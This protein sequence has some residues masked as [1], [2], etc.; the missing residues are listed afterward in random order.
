MALI[1]ACGEEPGRDFREIL[2]EVRVC[3]S[4]PTVNGIDVSYYQGTINWDRVAAAGVR[5]A[6]IRTGDGYFEDPQFERN[7]SEARR[8][9]IYRGAYHYFRPDKSPEDQADIVVSK[10]G[11]LGAGDLPPVIDL[12][13]ESLYSGYTLS[14]K[15]DKVRRFINR[16]ESGTGR[17]VMIY[18]GKYFWQDAFNSSN[19][20]VDH[21]L[22][23]PQYG[24]TCPDLPT[25]W[26]DWLFFQTS[27]RGTVPGIS[28]NVDLDLFNGDMADLE[29]VANGAIPDG[30]GGGGGGGTG[31]LQGVVF[32]DVGVGTAD[33]SR[34][35][36]GAQ[37][38]VSGGPSTTARASDAFWYLD[39]PPGTYT[40]TASLAGYNSAS[41]TCSVSAGSETWCSIGLTTSSNSGD[42]SGGGDSDEDQGGGGSSGGDSGDGD[43][44][45]GDSG[46]GGGGEQIPEGK[47]KIWG[48]VVNAMT[49][50]DPT[51]V[52]SAQPVPGALVNVDNQLSVTADSNGYFQAF[53]DP[54]EI[55]L[56]ASASGYQSSGNDCAVAEGQSVECNI[57]M[58]PLSQPD[59]SEQ[60]QLQDSYGCSCSSTPH[61]GS[62]LL[63]LLLTLPMAR[64]RFRR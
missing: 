23:I 22:W 50:N 62:L 31:T 37:V 10:L 2:Q 16:V 36:A 3:A 18:T 48:R 14:Q 13:N 17:Q 20:F 11:R 43:S 8:V 45:G 28:G 52:S 26:T 7:W 5:F 61:S 54:G 27:D 46:S 47:G 24:P 21:P 25:P 40:V 56:L 19:A 44:A 63:L 51:E 42:E 15:L 59:Q 34:R 1:E 6:I 29:R 60:D 32:E 41:R 9:G 58:P 35:L 38:T 33:M 4:G 53:V 39:L 12:E 64:Y 49:V 30:G 57:F 55:T